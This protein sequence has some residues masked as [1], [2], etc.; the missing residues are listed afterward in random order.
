MSNLA[1]F[2]LGY[3]GVAVGIPVLLRI[4]A[5]VV[6]RF[7]RPE[8]EPFVEVAIGS[9]NGEPM[10]SMLMVGDGFQDQLAREAEARWE[11]LSPEEQAT[12]LAW[13]DEQIAMWSNWAAERTGQ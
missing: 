11:A 1:G 2:Y 10:V 9:Y 7:K 4:V 6:A 5:L 8:P 3:Y 12:E 13:E